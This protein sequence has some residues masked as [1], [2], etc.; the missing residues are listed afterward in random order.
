MK[1]KSH[2]DVVVIGA[3]SVGMPAAFAM[4]K[5]GLSVLVLDKFSSVGQGSNKAAIGGVRAT[6]SDPAKIRLCLRSIEIIST[7][8]ET[9]GHDV[10]WR[11]GGY[12][13]VAYTHREERTLKDLLEIQHRYGLN[14]DWHDAE[15]LLEIVPDLNPQGLIGGTYSPTT[16]TVH[17][18]F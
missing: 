12:L 8:R 14:I 10:E 11:P 17:P 13:F 18:C 4:A 6:H 7:W 1:R 3:G 16:G 2:Y 15:G 9:H 5:A